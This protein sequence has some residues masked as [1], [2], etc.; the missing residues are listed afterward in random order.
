[1]AR[2]RTKTLLPPV[3]LTF[4]RMASRLI[5]IPQAPSGRTREATDPADAVT[6]AL[7]HV[8]CVGQ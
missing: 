2:R 5:A 4:I 6:D 3:T 7:A 1:M 8:S